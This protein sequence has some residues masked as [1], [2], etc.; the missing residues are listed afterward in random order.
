MSKMRI[1]TYLTTYPLRLA[2]AVAASCVSSV[3]LTKHK[4]RNKMG[5]LLALRIPRWY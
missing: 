5:P 4:Q 3:R 1:I 2:A